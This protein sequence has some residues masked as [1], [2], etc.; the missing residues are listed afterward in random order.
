MFYTSKSS[1]NLEVI[2]YESPRGGPTLEDKN[3]LLT[4]LQLVDKN[5]RWETI[6]PILHTWEVK[7]LIGWLSDILGSRDVPNKLSF[8]EPCLVIQLTECSPQKDRFCFRFL[9]SYEAT[10]P[11]WAMPLDD[12]YP[13]IIECNRTSIAEAIGHLSSQL[14]L[15]PIRN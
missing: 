5:R 12:P 13:L 4:C 8:S 6:A 11:W 9:L 2:N 14:A 7:H 3:L 15:F 10:P 1:F